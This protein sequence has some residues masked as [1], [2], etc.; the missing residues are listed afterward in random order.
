MTII[1]TS[2]D[3]TT[4]ER[5]AIEERHAPYHR[6]K[7]F[8]RGFDDYQSGRYSCPD[9]WEENSV[10]GQAWDRGS[11]TAMRLHW[12]RHRCEYARDDLDSRKMIKGFDSAIKK[13]RAKA[14]KEGLTL[15]AWLQRE[16]RERQAAQERR[17]TE[18]S[19]NPFISTDMATRATNDNVIN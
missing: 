6:F 11:E 3:L 1:Y 2:K 16:R 18:E 14:A 10:A 17:Q 12:E 5:R 9:G 13:L 15:E 7:A 4:T 19:R 8:W